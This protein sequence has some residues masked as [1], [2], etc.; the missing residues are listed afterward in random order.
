MILLQT[1]PLGRINIIQQAEE[2]AES[3]SCLE[4][5]M[6]S[7]RL[8]IGILLNISMRGQERVKL[9]IEEARIHFDMIC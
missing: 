3:V 6:A 7:K 1:W 8:L 2:V 9:G 5:E 4:I